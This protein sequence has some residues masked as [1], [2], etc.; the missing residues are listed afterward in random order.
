[1]DFN[2]NNQILLTPK[3]LLS[4]WKG[5]VSEGTLRNW[6]TEGRGPR[7][8]KPHAKCILYPLDAVVEYEQA[9]T[10]EPISLVG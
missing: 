6:R 5:M 9:N 4:R 8:I 10:V 2:D 7:Y 1:M 3:E